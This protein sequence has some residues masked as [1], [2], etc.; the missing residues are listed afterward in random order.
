MHL[1]G[2]TL[3]GVSVLACAVPSFG[4][5]YA[6]TPQGSDR[7]GDVSGPWVI[8]EDFTVNSPIRITKLGIFDDG[9]DG[10]TNAMPVG[11]Y[12]TS[13]QTLVPGL[14]GTVPAGTSA[15]ILG[16]TATY[17]NSQSYA[18]A[19]GR[20]AGFRYVTLTTPI[21]LPAG[22]Y[23]MVGANFSNGGTSGAA[24][25][26]TIKTDD[27]GETTPTFNDGSGLISLSPDSHF[28][29]GTTLVFPT[30]NTAAN[31]RFATTSF[32][33]T[34]VPEPTTI[35]LLSLGGLLLMRRRSHA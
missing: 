14:S 12:N 30:V 33:F 28:N 17:V 22:T 6:I 31:Y 3:L 18:N 19:A 21:D 35:G 27:Y 26:G 32:E 16:G 13:T 4:A 34:A 9:A 29:S 11:I 2:Q 20:S 25:A 24:A 23:S 7:F 8:R 1:M 10:L 15:P 5:F